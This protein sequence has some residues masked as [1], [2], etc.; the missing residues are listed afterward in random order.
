MTEPSAPDQVV[1]SAEYEY[2]DDFSE[3]AEHPLPLDDRTKIQDEGD[4]T[5]P[6]GNEGS[7][8]GGG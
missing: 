6:Y 5:G 2:E 8:E 3:I 7:L 1:D 4:A